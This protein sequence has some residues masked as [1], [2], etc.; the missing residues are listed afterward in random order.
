[1]YY[2]YVQNAG[3]N[4][5][6][7]TVT[8]QEG[9]SGYTDCNGI[10]DEGMTHTAYAAIGIGT[11]TEYCQSIP[12]APDDGIVLT[13]TQPVAYSLPFTGMNALSYGYIICSVAGQVSTDP[14]Y[15]STGYFESE[16]TF[17]KAVANT[18]NLVTACTYANDTTPDWAGPTHNWN[19]TQ[20]ANPYPLYIETQRIAFSVT[21]LPSSPSSYIAYPFHAVTGYGNPAAPW[22]HVGSG[23]YGAPGPMPQ[24]CTQNLSGKSVFNPAW[25]PA[26]AVMH[27]SL[28]I[29]G[30]FG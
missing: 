1:M 21:R 5:P 27:F 13:C 8:L 3:F 19:G 23:D 9:V 28:D 22:V 4:G 15:V 18:A 25:V 6:Q 30:H 10:C 2:T 12:V 11:D 14:N 29:A 20:G 16:L 24:Q 17:V 26:P 7:T